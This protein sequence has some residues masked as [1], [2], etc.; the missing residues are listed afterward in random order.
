MTSRT[1]LSRT[2]FIFIAAAIAAASGCTTRENVLL[3][4]RGDTATTMTV[5]FQSAAEVVGVV[6]YDTESR[7]GAPEEY[8]RSVEAEPRRIGGIDGRWFYTA[9]LTGLEPGGTYYFVAGNEET[10]Y[11]RE[12]KFKTLPESGPVRFAEGGD[13]S[14]LFRARKLMRIAASHEP[15][16]A[17]IGGDIAYANGNE[18][19]LWVWDLWM[20]HYRHEF[21]TPDGYLVPLMF[22]IGN[23][24][25]NDSDGDLPKAQ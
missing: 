21:V 10:G 23:H 17:V 1:I 8:A 2:R 22:A 24:E 9:E 3:T 15:D 18:D 13:Q 7:D 6:H 16:F 19:S 14:V 12:H 20:F 11:S 5:N 4:W 25:V